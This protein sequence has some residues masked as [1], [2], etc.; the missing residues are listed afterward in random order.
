MRPFLEPLARRPRLQRPEGWAPL[1]GERVWFARGGLHRIE[2]VTV[3]LCRSEDGYPIAVRAGTHGAM[4]L[5]IAHLERLWPLRGWEADRA[6]RARE[7]AVGGGEVEAS[8]LARF[9]AVA[10]VMEK[11]IIAKLH[12]ESVLVSENSETPKFRAVYGDS[13]ENKS[14]SKYTPS[15]SLELSITNP[16]AM[17]FFKPG[18]D[19]LVTITPASVLDAAPDPV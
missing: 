13:E 18:R 6:K 11:N 19:Y 9:D 12:C 16:Q 10:P 3:G 8:V 5:G 15:A 2:I 17:G 1:F 7:D 4:I 14:F